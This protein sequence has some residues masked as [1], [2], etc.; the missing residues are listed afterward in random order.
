LFLRIIDIYS[1]SVIMNHL[2][3]LKRK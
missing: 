1:L 2:K 3:N